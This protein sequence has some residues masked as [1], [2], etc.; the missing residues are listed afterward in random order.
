MNK[1]SIIV[2]LLLMTFIITQTEPQDV[3]GEVVV[4]VLYSAT[5]HDYPPFSVTSDG[6]A[7]GFSVELLRAVAEEMGYDIQFEIDQWSVIKDKLEHDEL[8]VLPLVGYTEERDQYFDFTVPYIVMKGNIFVRKGDNQIRSQADLFGKDILVL[9]GDNSEEWALSIGLDD[10]LT[11]TATYTEAF[12]LL[13]SGSYDAVLA[14]GLVGEKILS[15]NNIESIQPVYLYDDNGVTRFK[16]NLEGYEQK[17]SF[18]VT[19]GD[20]ALL[21]EL[22]EGLAIVSQNGT[23]D[24]LYQKWFPFLI[25]DSPLTTS[26]ILRVVLPILGP[27]VVVILAI[28]IGIMKRKIEAKKIELQ[29]V[30]RHNQV[31][32]EALRKEL[33][34]DENSFAYIVGE[35]CKIVD[36]KGGILFSLDEYGAILLRAH[37][38]EHAKTEK[39]L[40]ELYH[41]LYQ[42]SSM[43]TKMKTKQTVYTTLE[44]EDDL[45]SYTLFQPYQNYLLTSVPGQTQT[46]VVLLFD[47]NT[48]NPKDDGNQ[49]TI[50]L[51]SL[52][53]YIEQYDRRLKNEYL[54]Y[55]D[56]LTG[57]YNRRFFDEE[58]RRL[59]NP[60]NLPITI[61]LGDVND[62]K[63]LNDT[64]GHMAGDIL[65]Q[66]IGAILQQESRKN[67]IV[68]RWGGDEFAMISPA[69]SATQATSLIGRLDQQCK[70]K[71]DP[72]IR[73]SISFGQ[74]TKT[75]PN[76]AIR[77]CF[78]EAEQEMYENKEQGKQRGEQ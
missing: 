2:L 66:R 60:R 10:E 26:D 20:A 55:H 75:D 28:N 70:Q 36:A 9:D 78:K 11:A 34:T 50:L 64:R 68:A 67:D 31:V 14:N 16:L 74:A 4:P 1:L 27:I 63:E 52:W 61:V 8:D 18:A 3:Q 17:F 32:V 59:D 19:E 42:E 65:L 40:E 47:I 69:T 7:D 35:L 29:R 22:N 49:V 25:G 12:D 37:N 72:D 39:I 33:K 73:L 56:E 62:L 44:Q 45:F 48:N 77:D 54:S 43:A 76:Q 51:N 15:E 13:A 46:H 6:T 71:S 38:I 24:E 41:V 21:A 23:Y 5:E 53:N 30:Y 57:L 58:L